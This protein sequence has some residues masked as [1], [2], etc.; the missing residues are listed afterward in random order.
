MQNNRK[1]MKKER[2][3]EKF[4]SLSGFITVFGDKNKKQVEDML[5]QAAEQ[6]SDTL[7]IDKIAERMYMN[8]CAERLAPRVYQFRDSDGL[9]GIFLTVHERYD[10]E[11]KI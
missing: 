4:F 5:C 7:N 2:R 6:L 8:L 3:I 9:G 10:P 11:R 1:K